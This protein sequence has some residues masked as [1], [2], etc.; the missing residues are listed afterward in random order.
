MAD[1][2]KSLVEG[3]ARDVTDMRSQVEAVKASD[4]VTQDKLNK[5]ADDITAKMAELQAKQAKLEAASQRMDAP[6]PKDAG[7]SELNDY[8]RKGVAP[9]G[10][11]ISLADGLEVRAMSTDVN[12]DGGFLVRPAL[13]NFV[14]D[15]IIETSPVRRLANVITIGTQGLDVLIDDN[16]ATSRWVAE[17]PSGG[18]TATPQVG[19]KTIMAH[20]QEAAPKVTTEQIEDSYLDVEGWLSGKV[21][22][23]FARG[24]NTAFV[25]GDGV[26]RPR[27]FVSYPAWATAGAYERDK[28]ERINSGAAANVAVNGLIGIQNALKE[29]YQ[30]GA[31]WAMKRTT[32]GEVLKLKSADNYN[33][34]NLSVAPGNQNLTMQILQKPVTFMDDMAAVGAGAV[35]AAYADWRRFYTIVDRVGLQILRDPFTNK[36]FVTFYTYKRVG[37]D[38]TSFDAGKLLVCAA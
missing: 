30:A 2:I 3:I 15:R 23:A 14:I 4:F 36:G 5:A 1:E 11:K 27:G 10:V 38:V 17:G 21:V 32:F 37:G 18:E 31:S 7:K 6:D 20:K 13:A 35:V 28:V 34:L 26:G 9:E 8:L 29:D 22:D 19:R 24:E 16:V 12:A 33:F 25:S